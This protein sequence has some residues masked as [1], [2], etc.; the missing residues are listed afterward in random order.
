MA[1]AV[2]VVGA[3]VADGGVVRPADAVC[4]GGEDLVDEV[5]QHLAHQFRGC[6]GEQF[7]KKCRLSVYFS[8][9]MFLCACYTSP[10]TFCECHG[11]MAD[12]QGKLDLASSLS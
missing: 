11:H 7:I 3:G 4:L 1:V 12:C 10:S 6:L 8:S 5:L 9:T 2:S